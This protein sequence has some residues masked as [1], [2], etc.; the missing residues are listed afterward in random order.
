MGFARSAVAL[1]RAVKPKIKK[2]RV[3]APAVARMPVKTRGPLQKMS[4]S[5]LMKRSI[6]GRGIRKI[7]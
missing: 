2:N 5:G 1:R 6:P 3:L 7:Y 4:H